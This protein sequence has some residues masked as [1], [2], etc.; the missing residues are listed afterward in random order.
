MRDKMK[1]MELRRHKEI[2]AFKAGDDSI[3]AYHAYNLEVAE[4]S[5][6]SFEQMTPITITNGAI[7]DVK[8]PVNPVEREAVEALAQWSSSINES[9]KTGKIDFGIRSINL[10][11][12]QICN[13]K[14]SYCAAGGDGTYG[15]P[16]NKISVEKTLPQ[17]RFFMAQL[18]PGQKFR[19]IIIGGE[20]LLYPEAIQAIYD[21]TKS[22]GEA[23]QITPI[24]SIVTNGTLM[25]GRT[26][27]MIRSMKI[28][29]KISI[30]GPKEVNDIVRPTKNNSS[31]TDLTTAAIKELN[32]DRGQ[33][34]SVC[35]AAVF[36]KNNTDLVSAYKF[37]RSFNPDQIEL[38]FDTTETSLELQKKYIDQ[39]NLVAKEAWAQGKEDEL[40]KISSFNQF[41]NLLDDQLRLENYCGAGK[42]YLMVDAKNKLYTCVWTA[43][44]NSEVVGQNEQ[45]DHEQLA[46][47]AKSLIELNNC[48]TCWARHLCGGG[49]MFINKMNNGDKHK[50]DILFCERMRSLILTTLLY[51]KRSRSISA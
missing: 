18:K 35:L 44:D 31:S 38:T 14:C 15:Q 49:C 11:V 9:A 1:P 5:P 40:K 46:K 16:T 10:N 3:T 8:V 47:Y 22:E 50:K 2:I 36:S 45:L 4:I 26:L 41:F 48:Q 43:G 33:V 21:Y 24:I 42:N 37:L 20:P 25:V 34:N 17:L 27:E 19:I 51:Y 32:K 6:E 39:I 13:L 29:V 7:P 28:D 12:N 30:D 23:R